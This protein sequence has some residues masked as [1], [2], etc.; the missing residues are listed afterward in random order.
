MSKLKLKYQS[1]PFPKGREMLILHTAGPVPHAQIAEAEKALRAKY[2]EWTGLFLVFEPGT[3]LTTM[4][5]DDAWRLYE[6]LRR[7]FT[8]PTALAA[9]IDDAVEVIEKP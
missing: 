2:P 4:S 1:L 6:E 3:K 8:G 5:E 9:D 7:R